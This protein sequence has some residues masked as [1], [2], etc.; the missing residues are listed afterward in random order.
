MNNTLSIHASLDQVHDAFLS[1]LSKIE[2]HARVSFR[3]EKC[4]GTR[5]DRIAETIAVCWMWFRRLA[6]RG[7]D[8][9]AFPAV[10]ASFVARQV[11]SGRRLCGQEKP[12]DVL[13]PRAQQ[14]R[15]FVVEKLPDFSTMNGAPVEEALHDNSQTPVPDQVVFRCDFPRWRSTRTRRDR[16]L[17]NDL[18]IGERT[19]DVAKKF[20]ISAGRVSQLREDF[21]RDWRR[22]VNELPAVARSVAATV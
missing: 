15:G 17:M 7:K 13:S 11:K 6:N 16:R 21:H 12:N 20:S 8:A 4:P 14:L 22:F 10:L 5:A 2:T 19:K 9:T 1:I 18:M 3:H